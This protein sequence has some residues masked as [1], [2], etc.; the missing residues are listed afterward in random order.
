MNCLRISLWHVITVSQCLIFES[1]LFDIWMIFAWYLNHLC[2]IFESTLFDIWIMSVWY[3]N[4]LYLI[5]ESSLL[6]IWTISNIW[7]ISIWYLNQLCV[8]Q[9]CLKSES[10]VRKLNL[11]FIWITMNWITDFKSCGDL[12]FQECLHSSFST[13]QVF[14]SNLFHMRFNFCCNLAAKQQI[15]WKWS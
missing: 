3:L 14:F 9:L 15:I 6:D 1:P 8:N 2:L 7:I 10:G 12:N 11:F 13:F 5:S 4:H